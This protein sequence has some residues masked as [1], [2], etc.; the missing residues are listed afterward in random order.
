ME[1]MIKADQIRGTLVPGFGGR[2]GV[3]R[4]GAA[5]SEAGRH[6]GGI[7]SDTP[8]GQRGAGRGGAGWGLQMKER[9]VVPQ[10]AGAVGSLPSFRFA[11]LRHSI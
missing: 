8:M 10:A 3:V 1:I 7:G 4:G 6:R 5:G 9:G 11:G 2:E